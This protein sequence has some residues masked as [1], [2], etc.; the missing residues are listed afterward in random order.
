MRAHRLLIRHLRSDGVALLAYQKQQAD[1][2]ARRPQLFRRQNL[3]RNDPLGVACSSSIN[4]PI[5]LGRCD[6]RWHG[7]HVSREKNLR[8]PVSRPGRDHIRARRFDR[9]LPRFESAPLQFVTEKIAN[10]AF[11][12]SNGFDIDQPRVSENR[13]MQEKSNSR[14]SLV[15]SRWRAEFAILSTHANDE[16]LTINDHD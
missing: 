8:P 15:A 5:I 12:R 10:R 6:E 7:V 13:S 1:E 11:I 14:W 16:R 2:I 4:A 3:R 9:H